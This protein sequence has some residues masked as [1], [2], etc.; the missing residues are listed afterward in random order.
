MIDILNQI[1]RN[2]LVGLQ[3]RTA[4]LNGTGVDLSTVAAGLGKIVLKAIGTAGTLDCKIQDSA[5]NST[6][7]DVTGLAFTQVTGTSL[8]AQEL[9]LDIRSVRRYVR[10][11]VTI[12]SSGSF[13]VDVALFTFPKVV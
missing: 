1:T 9:G 8:S 7:A 12:G 2:D 13:Y 5:D 11:V 10:A 4:N 3:L 6:F